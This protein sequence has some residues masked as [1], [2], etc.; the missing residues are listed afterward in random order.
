M[1]VEEN[2]QSTALANQPRG[3][4]QKHCFSC[5]NVIH[6]TATQ[7][8]TCG[9]T[10]PNTPTFTP[11]ASASSQAPLAHQIFCRGC[12]ATIHE[13]ASTCPKCGAPQSSGIL[14]TGQ[15]SRIVAAIL[16][17][18]LG[19][20]GVHKFYLGQIG[21]GFLYLI[22]CWTF[23]PTIIAFIEGIIYLTMSDADFARKY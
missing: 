15:K 17:F 3:A 6:A 19:A 4:D 13:S 20:F 10:Q 21:L 22:F 12:G 1:T 9:A 11:A 16:A 7:C 14:G 8:P 23:I 5:G 2:Q 18:F